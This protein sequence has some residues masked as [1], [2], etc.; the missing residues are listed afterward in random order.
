[1]RRF[2]AF[3]CLCLAALAAPAKAGPLELGNDYYETGYRVEVDKP[4]IE[5]AFVA[6]RKIELESDISGTLHAVSQDLRVRGDIGENLLG[7]AEE[8]SIES[9]IDGSALALAREVFVD[10]EVG[11]KLRVA[12]Q[13]L[14]IDGTVRS[15]SAAVEE[16]TLNGEILGDAWIAADSI[17]FGEG[18]RIGGRLV[19]ASPGEISIPSSVIPESRVEFVDPGDMDGEFGH[20]H[21]YD[22]H[23]GDGFGGHV[24]GLLISAAVL[25]LMSLVFRERLS[26]FTQTFADRPF[27]TAWTG[28]L[29]VSALLGLSLV[30]AITIIGLVLTAA[31]FLAIGVFLVAG[32]FVGAYMLGSL[33][34]RLSPRQVESKYLAGAIVSVAGVILS[35]LLWHVPF[36]GFHLGLL[37]AMTAVGAFTLHYVRPSFFG[38]GGAPTPA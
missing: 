15:L 28:I 31:G 34:L 8:I 16:L 2:L 19:V 26:G 37:V 10:G 1:M 20:D 18:A 4:G 21:H 33:A 7:A 3:F 29:A 17:D 11:E 38:G 6:A 35:W 13:T 32:N 5:D 14:K 27:K 24:A 36:V 12:S 25:F 30:S 23:H 22:D 9:Y